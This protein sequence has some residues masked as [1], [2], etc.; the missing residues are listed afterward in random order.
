[1]APSLHSSQFPFLCPTIPRSS[2]CFF[3]FLPSYC[4]FL[5]LLLPPSLPPLFTC[6]LSSFIFTCLLYLYLPLPFSL[7]LPLFLLPSFTSLNFFCSLLPQTTGP[8]A[9]TDWSLPPPNSS[10]NPP[11]VVLPAETAAGLSGHV[12]QLGAVASG[13]SQVVAAQAANFAAAASA[14]G[15]PTNGVPIN[16]GQVGSDYDVL[17]NGWISIVTS[18]Y[19]E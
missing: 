13:A 17:V 15:G 11:S 12:T 7:Y 4:L 14:L 1:M 16:L 6:L 5:S 19:E 18:I 8:A 10:P 3:S 9:T 2:L